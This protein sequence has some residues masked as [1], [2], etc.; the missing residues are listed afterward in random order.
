MAEKDGS[1]SN[2]G[3][4]LATILQHYVPRSEHESILDALA[5]L[6]EENTSLRDS[7][8]KFDGVDAGKLRDRISELEGKVRTRSHR[9]AFD[10]LAED[11]RI[12]DEFKE[13]I[14]D[15]IK[16]EMT[17]DEPDTKAM[18]GRLKDWLGER[19]SR[20]HYVRPA[21]EGEGQGDGEEED[22]PRSKTTPQSSDEGRPAAKPKLFT[23]GEDRGR[24]GPPAN[25]TQKFRYRS[26]D[27][28]NHEWMKENAKAYAKAVAEGRAER[29][30]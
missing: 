27:L 7:L 16:F 13:D 2:G 14:F 10:K 8:K 11:F 17:K 24:G 25:G 15:V 4:D 22:F 28:S 20:K 9:D 5:T 6:D 18:K 23:E 19:E 21:D 3:M 30:N 29:I 26:S 1:N 12:K